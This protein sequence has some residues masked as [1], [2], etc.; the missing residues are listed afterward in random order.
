MALWNCS[1]DADLAARAGELPWY[2]AYTRPRMESTA[3]FNL[4]RQGFEAYLP[5]YK[6]CRSEAQGLQTAFEP[7]FA[8][9][10]F[11]RPADRRQSLSTV[12]STRGV[13]GLI[14]FGG[15][16]ARLPAQTL[17]EIR[18][19]EQSRR[20]AN[21]DV[22]SPIQPGARVHMRNDRLKGI[23]GL[24]VSVAR[25]R[26]TFLLQMLGREKEVTVD[27]RELEIA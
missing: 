21:L 18:N 6:T 9:Y 17:Q 24:V 14:R 27:H 7:M 3:L 13:A 16:V 5:L 20:Q 25:Q 2:V 19:F 10:V 15:E 26:V 11:L 1:T 22:I 4:E 8:R 12:A 23:E